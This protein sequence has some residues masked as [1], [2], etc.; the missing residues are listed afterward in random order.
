MTLPLLYAL[1]NAED[2]KMAGHFKQLLS[3]RGND[4]S[5]EDIRQLLDFAHDNGGIDYA[6]DTMRRMQTEAMDILLK[7]PESEW[8]DAFADLFEFI[9]SR[10]R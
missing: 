7:Y 2:R 5:P 9:I 6:Y 8:R 1:N 4:L 10:D 3:S